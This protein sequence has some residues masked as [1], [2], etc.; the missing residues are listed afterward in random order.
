MADLVRRARR[1]AQRPVRHCGV[2]GHRDGSGAPRALPE[3]GPRPRRGEAGLGDCPGQRDGTTALRRHRRREVDLDHLRT[4]RLITARSPL[5]SGGRPTHRSRAT[6]AAMR[7]VGRLSAALLVTT[8][9]VSVLSPGVAAQPTQADAPY[10][11]APVWSSCAG[12]VADVSQL[13][14]AQ[15]GTVAVPVDYA[16]PQGAQAQ[17]AIIKVPATG[18]RIGVLIV[19]PGGPGASAVDTVAGMGAALA[20]T[21]ILQRFDLVGIDPRGVG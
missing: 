9:T 3:A 15:C 14:T 12:V 16:K 8:A 10:S 19:N 11:A 6:M 17:L 21:E 20:D 4:R 7:R 1:R 5:R 2:A 13:P 18:P